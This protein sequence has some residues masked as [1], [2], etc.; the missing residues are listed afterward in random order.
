MEEEMLDGGNPGWTLG[1]NVASGS[2]SGGDG[3]S[4]LG[5]HNSGINRVKVNNAF[6]I[7]HLPSMKYHSRLP[8]DEAFGVEEFQFSALHH[9][10][11]AFQVWN[12]FFQKK[13]WIAILE[14]TFKERMKH[15]SDI[16]MK[17]HKAFSAIGRRKKQ[18]HH[19]GRLVCKKCL[20]HHLPL[21]GRSDGTSCSVCTDCLLSYFYLHSLHYLLLKKKKKNGMT[22]YYY[23]YYYY[24]INKKNKNK[25]KNKHTLQKRLGLG[26]RNSNSNGNSNNSNENTNNNSSNADESHNENAGEPDG[27]KRASTKQDE[28]ENS[29]SDWEPS[30]SVSGSMAPNGTHIA[31]EAED[32]PNEDD[33]YS[34]TPTPPE[35]TQDMS[36]R[37]HPASPLGSPTPNIEEPVPRSLAEKELEKKPGGDQHLVLM[38]KSFSLGNNQAT[39]IGPT[40]SGEG[41]KEPSSHKK[42]VPSIGMNTAMLTIPG[43]HD[44]GQSFNYVDTGFAEDE[45]DSPN[46]LGSDRARVNSSITLVHVVGRKN[47]GRKWLDRSIHKAATTATDN[48]E[49]QFK[50]KNVMDKDDL[51]S[52][53]EPVIRDRAKKQTKT[54]HTNISLIS[55]PK[56]NESES[57]QS[58]NEEHENNSEQKSLHEL[59]ST[60][61]NES[62]SSGGGG[63]S[64]SHTGHSN[65]K[66]SINITQVDQ[67]NPKNVEI[68]TVSKK[69]LTKKMY[70]VFITFKQ[71]FKIKPIN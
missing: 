62:A 42:N 37:S 65:E 63:S 10:P 51:T 50:T 20:K 41:S 9:I 39:V 43:H 30:R 32:T 66:Y 46:E 2:L 58:D 35:G 19:C 64:N 13:E 34:R 17:C 14:Q 57:E 47:R 25:N 69:A 67:P 28:K 27:T 59:V 1:S 38:D 52:S 21:F 54:R 26:K 68:D 48:K 71:L 55:L 16:C 70:Y 11:N 61:K 6:D 31:V 8:I 18:C 33:G 22:S 24:K 7:N 5:Q 15:W 23:Y 4:S 36:R 44:R 60:V 29:S 53:V 49:K 3:S 40:N 45:A 12:Y 56:I